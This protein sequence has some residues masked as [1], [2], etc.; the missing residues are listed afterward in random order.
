ME[1]IFFTKE[2]IREFYLNFNKGSQ[3]YEFLVATVLSKVLSKEW[4]TS[5]LIGFKLKDRYANDI[6]HKGSLNII[7]VAQLLRGKIDNDTPIDVVIVPGTINT[8]KRHENKGKAFQFKR[9]RGESSDS[10]TERL[11][12]YLNTMPNRYAKTKATL[13]IIPENCSIIDFKKVQDQIITDRYPFRCIMFSVISKGELC[14]GE[15]WPNPG[16]N[17]YTGEINS[18]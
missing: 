16:F 17:K 6:P 12:E 9:F 7:E 8:I 13:F 3:D 5:C 4:G 15:I 18:N 14:I 2:T 10:D 11:I 1:T